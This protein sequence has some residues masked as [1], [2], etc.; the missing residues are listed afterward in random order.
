MM[1]ISGAGVPILEYVV[2]ADRCCRV[3]D[4]KRALVDDEEDEDG[5]QMD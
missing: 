3:D 1:R 2:A 4:R 5:M